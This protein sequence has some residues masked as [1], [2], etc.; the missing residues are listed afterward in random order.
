MTFNSLI[1]IWFDNNKRNLPWRTHSDPYKIWISEIILQQT[2]VAQGIDY[3]L[4]FIETY[5]TVQDMAAASEQDILRLW[6][7]L[8]YYSRVRNLHATA[9]FIVENHRGKF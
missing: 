1:L 9:K 4:K 5:P 7:G 3:Y 8:G 2:R 6:Q